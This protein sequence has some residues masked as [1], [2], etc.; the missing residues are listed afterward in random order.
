MS[1][2]FKDLIRNQYLAA[3]R[4]L[5][6]CI[7]GCPDES[8]H[9]AVCNHS[10][11]QSVFHSLFFADVYLG[12]DPQAVEDQDFHRQ[13]ADVFAGYEE[14]EP[15][16]PSKQYKREFIVSYLD[17]CQEKA[18]FVI[19]QFTNENLE[20]RSG[21]DWIDGTVAEVH[22]YNI[23]HI[24]HHAAQLSLRLRLDHKVEVPWVK[25]GW[26]N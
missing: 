5:K 16:I 7:D 13:H 23:R 20:Q 1:T 10:F 3:F 14:W 21:F 11:S 2:L 18:K 6:H 26:E 9:Q 8:W 24:Q 12:A 25:S 22:V 19:G 15:S 4:T 17:H